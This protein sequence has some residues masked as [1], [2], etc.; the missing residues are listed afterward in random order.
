MKTGFVI[1]NYN[2]Y[3]TTKIIIEN[4]HEYKS[5]VEI[6][7]VDNCSTDNSYSKLL[8]LND[9][10]L[11]IIKNT[12]NK[13]Y[14][15]GMNVGAKYLIKKYKK[16]NIIFSNADIIIHNEEDIINLI[17]TLNKNMI[18]GIVA[19]VI[20]ERTGLNRGWKIP[21]PFQD[22]LLNL[23]YIHRYLRPKLLYYKPDYYE[24][25]VAVEAVSGCFFCMRSDVLKEVGF[26]DENT[27]LYYE[28]NIISKKLMA[29]GY[30]I[31]LHSDI[32]VFHN[33]SVTIDKSLHSIKKFKILKQSQ[34]YFQKTYNH[35][36]IAERFFLGVTSKISLYIL[37]FSNVIKRIKIGKSKQSK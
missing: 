35:A 6:V 2:D 22:G 10:K 1:V 11:S 17:K 18:Y 5:I 8:Q 23:L 25:I 7:V 21:T 9:S 20:E 15:S 3:E 26:F 19:P 14:A 37:Y 33:H 30:K 27:F 24:G 28:E 32:S 4:I 16:C 12:E 29:H 34:F 31:M 36:N 13:G